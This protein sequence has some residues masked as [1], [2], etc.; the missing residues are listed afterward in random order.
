MKNKKGF[1]L[2]E[3]LAVIAIIA[4]VATIGIFS[5]IAIK[6]KMD[7]KMFTST[8]EEALMASEKYGSDHKEEIVDKIFEEDEKIKVKGE[9]RKYKIITI[10]ELLN[11]KYI[12]SEDKDENN[13]PAII[14]YET[15]L[16]INDLIILLYETNDSGRVS[17]CIP[18]SD[19]KEE[20][21]SNEVLL[22]DALEYKEL[23]IT[24]TDYAPSGATNIMTVTVTNPTAW[25]KAK[26]VNI[27]VINKNNKIIGYK[28]VTDKNDCNDLANGWT[29]TG[30]TKSSG[31]KYIMSYSINNPDQDETG[32]TYYACIK[33]EINKRNKKAVQIIKI[34]NVN[35]EVFNINL[36]NEN[37][38]TKSKTL[39]YSLRDNASGVYGY[40]VTT[41]SCPTDKAS[42]TQGTGTFTKSFTTSLTAT[43]TTYK[44]C[45]RDIAGNIGST[46]KV[47]SKI[48]V[49]A[50]TITNVSVS[51]ASDWKTS[52]VLS[53]TIA[54]AH[55]G[56]Y[57][58]KVTTGSC[59]TAKSSY[60]QGSGG[61]N[62]TFNTNHSSTGTTYTICAIDQL[63]N[64]ASTTVTVKMIDI[65][66]P[67][68][69]L[70]GTPGTKSLKGSVTVN[71]SGGSGISKYQFKNGNGFWE[72]ST[73]NNKTYTYTDCTNKTIYARVV[74]GSGVV[75]D[76]KS[77]TKAPINCQTAD[78]KINAKL[79]GNLSATVGRDFIT[80]NETTTITLTTSS[81]NTGERSAT[82]KNYRSSYGQPI[83]IT[84]TNNNT[85]QVKGVREGWA[86]VE[87]KVAASDKYYAATALVDIYV[88]NAGYD[89]SG[90]TNGTGWYQD[91]TGYWWQNRPRTYVVSGWALLP[92]SWYT[93]GAYYDGNPKTSIGD[94]NTGSAYTTR[95]QVLPAGPRRGSTYTFRCKWFKFTSGGYIDQR[96]S[97]CYG[98]SID[99]FKQYLKTGSYI[100]APKTCGWCGSN[101]YNCYD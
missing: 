65:T 22:P 42:Y 67:T 59:P 94:C 80:S 36:T 21:V 38:W 93:N 15:D 23:G 83:T 43:G 28:L 63:E 34:D 53:F 12:S 11:D 35:P 4:V 73:V 24:C 71:S 54:D 92:E 9:N 2:V 97:G 30:I 1:T 26:T 90:S 52:K 78:P 95:P 19:I 5:S 100:N 3:L 29:T 57:G 91:D 45:V 85:F 7:K 87:V 6:K 88:Y 46:N 82:I 98:I 17:A 74:S 58:Y 55:S 81:D 62:Y 48:D 96:T 84:K 44:I 47:I 31:G 101:N 14:H 64:V 16:S 18:F 72:D 50:P 49:T 40:K 39:S 8:L 33:D 69:N 86:Q 27:S 37:T 68:I 89:H 77:V 76:Q 20:F 70:T 61:I 32:T 51:N 56:I 79:N 25:S 41:G 60:T 13:K 75:S 10:G 99:N 66:K